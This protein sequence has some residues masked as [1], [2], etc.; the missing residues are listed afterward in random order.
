MGFVDL[1]R[2]ILLCDVLKVEQGK[3]TPLRYVMLPPQLR[4]NVGDRCDDAG[5]A[6]DIAVVQQGRTLK[7]VDLQAY[8]KPCPTCRWGRP[9]A[10]DCSGDGWDLGYKQE[11][12]DI[13]VCSKPHFELPPKMLDD[14]GMPLESLERLEIRQPTL[15]LHDDDDDTVYFMTSKNWKDDK[16]WVIAVDMKNNT[17]QGVAEFVSGRAVGI[18]YMHSRISK[19]LTAAPGC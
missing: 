9:V 18:T 3:P 1:W 5:F 2:G 8:R 10:A 4:P 19:Y 6:R 14:G 15:S 13:T 16:A 11:S 7:Y 17:L 12:S